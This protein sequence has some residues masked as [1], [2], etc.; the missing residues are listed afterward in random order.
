MKAHVFSLGM[1]ERETKIQIKYF[2]QSPGWDSINAKCLKLIESYSFLK[3]L[4]N[5]SKKIK[6]K[7]KT[8]KEINLL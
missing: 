2:I 5:Y 3:Y 4:Y 7:E 8:K 1:K 6:V